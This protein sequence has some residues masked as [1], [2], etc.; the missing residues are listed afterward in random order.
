MTYIGR[1]DLTG[2]KY[3]RNAQRV[4][5][6]QEIEDAITAWTSERTVSQVLEEMNKAG[7]PVG[8]VA[9]VDDLMASEQIA[10]RGAVQIAEVESIDSEGNPSGWTVKMPGTFP[11]IDGV[12]PKPKWA[13]PNLGAHTEEILRQELGLRT[14]ELARLRRDG[15]IGIPNAS[16]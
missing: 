15:I 14:Y 12:D 7:V 6:Q 5:R 11:V 9:T 4:K 1:E 10:A 8:R 13:G 16:E 2:F 3:E